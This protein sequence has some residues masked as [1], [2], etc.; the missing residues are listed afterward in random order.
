M[1]IQVI[2]AGPPRTGTNSLG[3]ALQYL[4][5]GPYYHMGVIPGHPFD[6][7]EGWERAIANQP[8]DWKE[9]FDGY[10]AA[11]DWPASMFWRQLSTAYPEA[12][13]ILSV[14]DN[15]EAW[16]QSCEATFLPYARMA[17]SPDWE[18]GSGLPDLLERFTGT[19]EWDD[20]ATLKSAYE[21]YIVEVRQSVPPDRLLEWNPAQGWEPICQMLRLPVP[22]KPFPWVNKRSDWS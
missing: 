4:L 18:H 16:L 19:K 7:G 22:D 3:V 20:P 5:D 12:P 10:V 14:R 2:G 15:G 1:S 13:I 17:L 9:F 6:L 8:V 11:L 21:R